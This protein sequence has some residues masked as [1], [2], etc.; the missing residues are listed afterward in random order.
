MG[1]PPLDFCRAQLGVRVQAGSEPDH[2]ADSSAS[3]YA[4][5][6]SPRSRRRCGFVGKGAV[7]STAR[8]G[9]QSGFSASGS[10]L[11]SVAPLLV[12]LLPGMGVA[13]VGSWQY[14]YSGGPFLLP[15]GRV[16]QDPSMV[17]YWQG[18][19]LEAVGTGCYRLGGHR[20]DP[21]G[22]RF[23]IAERMN[24]SSTFSRTTRLQ[25]ALVI[26]SADILWK[27]FFAREEDGA[28][29]LRA[30]ASNRQQLIAAS[31]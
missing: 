28:S 9:S 11:L 16:V 26:G 27:A 10:L 17:A 6:G 29:S 7:G 20:G 5:G 30:R 19:V 31:C 24:H 22:C 14:A 21:P 8:A 18:M 15:M 23:Y 13:V 2:R 4:V 25:D 3:L 1:E 12:Q